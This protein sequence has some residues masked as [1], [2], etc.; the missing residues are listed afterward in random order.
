MS[1]N[2]TFNNETKT[3][4]KPVSVLDIV[5]PDKNIICALV[6]KRVRELT[7][8]IEKDSE[9]VPLT[10][11]DRDAKPTYEA[12]LRFLVA[13]AM[14][15][16]RPDLEIRFSYN[17]SRSVFLQIIQPQGTRSSMQMVKDLEAEMNRIVE[18]DYPLVRSIV[19]KEEA[20]RIFQQDGF[21]DKVKIL[22]YRPEK[23]AHI[24]TCNG[25]RLA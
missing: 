13:M 10:C 2:V 22:E 1:F 23:T 11:K 6:N 7:Y 24:Y 21:E 19:N 18:A 4:N 9:V 17:I 12:S 14:H 25:Y 16:I 5:G 20:K 3:Y 15:N 8:L